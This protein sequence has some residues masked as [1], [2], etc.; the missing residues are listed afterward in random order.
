MKF[1]ITA[2]PTREYID[3][4]RFISNPA[5]G[6]LGYFVAKRAKEHGH[7]VTVITGPCNFSEIKGIKKMQVES[8]LEMKNAVEKKF[9]SFD[10]LIMTAAV[11]DWR[12]AKRYGKKLKIK[13]PWKLKLVPNPDILQSVAQIKRE[14]QIV[15]GFALESDNIVKNAKEKLKKKKL[16]MLV[17]NTVEN[18]GKSTR[19]ARILVLYPDGKIKNC[20]GYSKRKLASFLIFEIERQDRLKCK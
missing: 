16:D 20:S 9:P 4:V 6:T 13:K 17:A 14:N 11:S 2:G 19:N 5:T 10:V 18:F 8:A 7:S 3:P 15:V 12:P 1:L